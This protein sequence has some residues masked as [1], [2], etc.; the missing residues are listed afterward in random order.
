MNLQSK[1]DLI[2]HVVKEKV[3]RS[4]YSMAEVIPFLPYLLF[5]PKEN[6][7]S[8]AEWRSRPLDMTTKNN[9]KLLRAYNRAFTKN[10]EAGLERNRFYFCRCVVAL[11]EKVRWP[12]NILYNCHCTS[13]AHE[14]NPTRE[15]A[16]RIAKKWIHVQLAFNYREKRG[17]FSAFSGG[18][19]ETLNRRWDIRAGNNA[20]F[21][22]IS[23][24]LWLR[25]VIILK[26]VN[27]SLFRLTS[28]ITDS[29]TSR[30]KPSFNES[31]I[32]LHCYAKIY[33][34]SIAYFL[35][36]GSNA[37]LHMSRIEC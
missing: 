33:I 7:F 23:I 30:H 12:M 25:L 3:A 36:P 10:D 21:H 27:V 24:F 9:K 4:T 1:Q 16:Y 6:I 37:A 35:G 22:V 17:C 32:H 5:P 28:A 2:C 19:Y 34:F 13:S 11:N 29:C 15:S 8:T 18:I 14:L 20:K 26:S 31:V